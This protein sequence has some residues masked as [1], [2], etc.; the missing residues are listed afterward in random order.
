MDQ[1]KLSVGEV[2]AAYAEKMMRLEESV[3]HLAEADKV[4]TDVMEAM[5]SA[6]ERILAQHTI[7]FARIAELLAGLGCDIQGPELS[8]LRKLFSLPSP[9]VN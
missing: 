4:N 7:A 6:Q 8:E 1:E 5:V 2:L 9:G 3:R